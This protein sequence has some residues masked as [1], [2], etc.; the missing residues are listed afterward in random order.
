MDTHLQND[1]LLRRAIAWR[2]EKVMVVF[3]TMEP[4]NLLQLHGIA[5][6]LAIACGHLPYKWTSMEIGAVC[7]FEQDDGGRSWRRF[8][9]DTSMRLVA[10]PLGTTFR[11][12][13]TH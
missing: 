11:D 5:S 2:Q 12:D 8:N 10:V 1:Y 4:I 13:P 6:E 3:R 7:Q 9:V